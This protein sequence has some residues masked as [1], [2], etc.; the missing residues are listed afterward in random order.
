[1]RKRVTIE[2]VSNEVLNNCILETL[3]NKQ[4]SNTESSRNIAVQ[5]AP[6]WL[7]RFETLSKTFLAPKDAELIEHKEI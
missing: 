2:V 7:P 6:L 4:L 1:M 3:L 5:D